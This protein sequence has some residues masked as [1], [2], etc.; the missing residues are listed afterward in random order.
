MD[1]QNVANHL[2][3]ANAFDAADPKTPSKDKKDL[4]IDTNVKGDRRSEIQTAEVDLKSGMNKGVLSPSVGVAS[5]S[6]E[7][8]QSASDMTDESE[9]DSE[10][11]SEEEE[12]SSQ[13]MEFQEQPQ[14]MRK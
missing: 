5:P 13:Q 6:P 12:S 2:K 9:Y 7:K 8:N 11:E 3:N 10:E 14:Q 4:V 1:T